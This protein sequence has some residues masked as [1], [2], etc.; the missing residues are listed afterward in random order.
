M[1]RLLPALTLGL[2]VLGLAAGCGGSTSTSKPA[3]VGV[4]KRASDAP[5]KPAAA[6]P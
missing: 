3:D 5:P 1:R 2:F 6:P 4:S